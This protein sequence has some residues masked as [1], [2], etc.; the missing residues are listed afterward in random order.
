MD[1][2][3][4]SWSAIYNKMRFLGNVRVFEKIENYLHGF[5][6]ELRT[7]ARL[8][9]VSV[10]QVGAGYTDRPLFCTAVAV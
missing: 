9:T 8:L 4:C 2:N 3:V 6:E 10:R 1:G 7:L 5:F